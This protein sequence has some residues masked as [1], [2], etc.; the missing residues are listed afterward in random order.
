[1]KE[2]REII[3]KWMEDVAKATGNEPFDFE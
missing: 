3:N 2:L 1:V